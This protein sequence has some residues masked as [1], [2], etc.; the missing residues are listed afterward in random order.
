[1]SHYAGTNCYLATS[2]VLA[3][4]RQRVLHKEEKVQNENKI[5]GL[6]LKKLRELKSLNRKEAGTLLDV[7][8][9]T[10]EKFENGSDLSPK[11]VPLRS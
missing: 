2:K 4:M 8:F 10:V 1:M 7:S 6:T 3:L 11:L 9:K 5:E